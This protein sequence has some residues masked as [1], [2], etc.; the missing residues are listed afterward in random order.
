MLPRPSFRSGARRRVLRIRRPRG[1]EIAVGLLRSREDGNQIVDLSVER[2]ILPDRERVRGR[3]DDLVGVGVVVAMAPIRDVAAVDI[4]GGLQEI[5]DATR[6][7][8][9]FED[10]WNRDGA[11]DVDSR[12]PEVVGDGDRIQRDSADR[13]GLNGLNRQDRQDG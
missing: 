3:F 6:D 11:V 7:L 9:L 12:T 4:V 5:V 1:V 10:V 2:R 13:I 8:V